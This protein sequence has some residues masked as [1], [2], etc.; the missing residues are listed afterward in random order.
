MGRAGDK[1]VPAQVGV[2]EEG[3]LDTLGEDDGNAFNCTPIS[4]DELH[5]ASANLT[6]EAGMHIGHRDVFVGF[7]DFSND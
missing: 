2:L 7:L 1:K 6:K 3:H 4:T 5:A